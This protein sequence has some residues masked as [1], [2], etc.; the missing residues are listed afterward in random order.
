MSGHKP[1]VVNVVVVGPFEEEKGEIG[2][3]SDVVKVKG[4]DLDTPGNLS[5]DRV[6]RDFGDFELS[7]LTSLFWCCF[8]ICSASMMGQSHAC[9][10]ILGGHSLFET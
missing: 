2:I 9:V 1:L 5:G 7:F 10:Q 6:G 3:T 8:P 4:E